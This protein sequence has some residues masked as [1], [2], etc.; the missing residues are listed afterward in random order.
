MSKIGWYLNRLKAMSPGEVMWRLGQKRL[1]R[2]ETARFADKQPVNKPLYDGVEEMVNAAMS[3]LLPGVDPADVTH[4]TIPQVREIVDGEAV[5]LLGGYR[6]ED[7]VDDWHAGFNTAS[8]WPLV[9]SYSLDYKQRDDIGDAR[10]N[11]ELNRHRQFVR[12]AMAGQTPRLAWL[13]DNW[14]AENPM[15]WGISWTSPMEIALRSM[16]WM[17][18]AKI[19]AAGYTPGD[20]LT[21]MTIRRLLTGAAN[22]TQY[23]V[24]HESGFSSA[25]NHLIVEVAAVAIAGLLFG[26]EDYVADSL[27]VL[28]RELPR[29]VSADGV[30]LESSLH[31]HG[32]VMEAY[33][34]VWQALVEADRDVPRLWRERLAG[35]ARF[36]A[37]SRAADGVWCVFGDDD[38]AR[39]SDLGYGDS[40]YFDS[41][42]RLYTEVSGERLET[43][44]SGRLTFAEGGYSF[45]RTPRMMVG[46]D[47]APLGFGA[48]AAHAH[49]DILSFQLFIDGRPVLVDSGT[50]LY[51]ID[52]ARRDQ[53]RSTAMHNTVTVNG[54]EQAQI[55]GPFLWGRKATGRLA[56]TADNGLTAAVTGLSGIEH[57]RR[58]E[59]S[60]GERETRESCPTLKITDSFSSECDWVATFI[61]APGLSVNVIGDREVMVADILLIVTAEGCISVDPVEIAP[62]YG[63]LADTFAVRIVGK[64][65]QNSVTLQS[66]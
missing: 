24:R 51:H 30:D 56:A 53:L 44:V 66:L 43:P 37:A 61:A 23:L 33:L 7:F 26:R 17:S 54:K 15:L 13:L 11:W 29:Q 34:L 55:L 9:P 28:D 50:Y 36:V 48:I 47:H 14:V 31:Y 60:E 39:I 18:A 3:R 59:L 65:R 45:L 40:D 1:Q 10:I 16:S 35:M 6:Y 58:W 49:N 52:R 25:N 8:R 46:V 57:T 63:I 12:L 32:F 27:R 62:A 20:A 4:V 64:S 2:S 5:R 38:E 21:L 41:L 19:L 42:L 22:M